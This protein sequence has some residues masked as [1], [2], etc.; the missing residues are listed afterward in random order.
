VHL[1]ARLHRR[2]E[3]LPLRR[4]RRGEQRHARARLGRRALGRHA[5]DPAD[6]SAP[7]SCHGEASGP[8][9]EQALTATWD[10][11]AWTAQ[12]QPFPAGVMRAPADQIPSTW[13]GAVA[14]RTIT[15]C[16]AVGGYTATNDDIGPLAASWNGIDWSQAV[17][18]R[19][20]VVLDSVACP[21]LGW[22]MAVGGTIAER[23]IG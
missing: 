3:L 21:A 15:S 11:T 10:G 19:R 22:C 20:P 14:C 2:R 23:L 16:A 18:R 13:L 8:A 7:R 5:L 6:D 1:D 12:V 17:L 4:Q 9:Q